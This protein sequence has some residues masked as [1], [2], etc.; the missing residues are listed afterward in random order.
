MYRKRCVFRH[1]PGVDERTRQKDKCR[2][3]AAGVRDVLRL[4]DRFT[5]P[6]VKLRKAVHP[7]VGDAVGGAS[8]YESGVGIFC[9]ARHLACGIVG[10]TKDR[11][12]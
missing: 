12:I 9:P 7:I 1:Q 6:R 8:V 4:D 10:Q 11:Y 3:I 5:L 2:W